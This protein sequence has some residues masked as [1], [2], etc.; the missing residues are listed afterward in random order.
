M[1]ENC[2]CLIMMCGGKKWNY[3]KLMESLNF[4][5]FLNDKERFQEIYMRKAGR[6]FEGMKIILGTMQW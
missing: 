6:N 1:N 5:S 2:K 3:Y 4:S